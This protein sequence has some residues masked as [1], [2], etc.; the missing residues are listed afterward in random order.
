MGSGSS[1]SPK[2]KSEPVTKPKPDTVSVKAKANAASIPK[3]VDDSDAILKD[4]IKHDAGEKGIASTETTETDKSAD[5]ENE[6]EVFLTEVPEPWMDILNEVADC[7][8]W[9]E[10]KRSERPEWRE[11]LAKADELFRAPKIPISLVRFLL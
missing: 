10:N 8:L 7:E 4:K 2:P 5:K 11:N 9:P 6:P 1:K 3:Q